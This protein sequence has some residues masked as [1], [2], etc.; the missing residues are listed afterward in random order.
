MPIR[1]GVIR[2]GQSSTQAAPRAL[3]TWCARE[4]DSSDET[5]RGV[6]ELRVS[7][8]G[9]VALHQP[10]TERVVNAWLTRCDGVRAE[11]HRGGGANETHT[12]GGSTGR[13]GASQ[14]GIRGGSAGRG[15]GLTGRRRR[16]TAQEEEGDHSG[17]GGPLSKRRE[18][19]Q[20]E[21]EEVEDHSENPL[22]DVDLVP[23]LLF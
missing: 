15:S 14:P 22:L 12:A 21:D 2:R 16:R 20:E 3:L 18:T 8:P 23:L 11:T 19:T 9:A 17:G 10:V 1:Q 6:L 13:W 4:E 7:A 5:I